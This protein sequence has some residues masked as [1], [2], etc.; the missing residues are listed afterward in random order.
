MQPFQLVLS[1]VL[2]IWVPLLSAAGSAARRTDT[3]TVNIVL[4]F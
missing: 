3:H 1:L 4:G 2:A